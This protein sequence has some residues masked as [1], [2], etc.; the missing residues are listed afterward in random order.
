MD[1]SRNPENPEVGNGTILVYNL[2][3][4]EGGC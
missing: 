3:L 2:F 1:A 4:S